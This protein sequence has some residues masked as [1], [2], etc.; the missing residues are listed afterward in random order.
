MDSPAFDIRPSMPPVTEKD[1]GMDKR[2]RS[3][4]RGLGIESVGDI[5]IGREKKRDSEI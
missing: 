1:T 5:E 3:G 2:Y 4:Y